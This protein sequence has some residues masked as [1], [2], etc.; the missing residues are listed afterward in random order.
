MGVSATR[1]LCQQ[2]VDQRQPKLCWQP[3]G[4]WQHL[5]YPMRLEHK[6]N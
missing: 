4:L 3:L 5:W 1:G 6:P 2:G